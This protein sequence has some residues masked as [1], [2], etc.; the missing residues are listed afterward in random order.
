MCWNY[1]VC[2][3][4][5]EYSIREVYY[6]NDNNITLISSEPDP[7]VGDSVKDVKLTLKLMKGALAQDVV[8]VDTVV[9]APYK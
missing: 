2:K 9:Y 1:R 5:D 3:Q 8:D 7:V 6:D 4:G